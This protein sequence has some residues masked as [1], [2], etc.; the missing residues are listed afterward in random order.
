MFVVTVAQGAV[1]DQFHRLIRLATQLDSFKERE[2]K[3]N[4]ALPICHLEA[5]CKPF[6]RSLR[7]PSHESA[8]R[9]PCRL[10]SF[11]R[12]MQQLAL[13]VREPVTGLVEV[14][15]VSLHV[16]GRRSCS[17]RGTGITC[18]T[19]QNSFPRTHSA[20]LFFASVSERL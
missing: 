10:P 16:S 6:W 13:V 15:E 1:P 3:K 14:K 18:P 20:T 5:T 19:G 9:C 11:V 17:M 4:S 2:L 7:I 8:G 12:I